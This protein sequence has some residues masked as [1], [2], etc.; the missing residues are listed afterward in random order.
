MRGQLWP[1]ADFCPRLTSWD[2]LTLT[3]VTSVHSNNHNKQ[4]ACIPLLYPP[5][6]QF[7]QTHR[8]HQHFTAVFLINAQ[9][10]R[11]VILELTFPLNEH[12]LLT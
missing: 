10:L 11:W 4:L 8:R 1:K 12:S 2:N 5:K 9:E 3:T 7:N 6:V